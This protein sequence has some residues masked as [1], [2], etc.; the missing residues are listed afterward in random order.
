MGLAGM[1]W[2][3]FLGHFE[4]VRS[5]DDV[6][7][8]SWSDSNWTFACMAR[9]HACL[10]QVS[11][12]QQLWNMAKEVICRQYSIHSSLHKVYITQLRQ[13]RDISSLDKSHLHIGRLNSLSKVCFAV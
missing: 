9:Q 10:V 5:P 2:W 11:P 12:G 7:F 6:H 1:R 8:I 4:F 3:L 13:L